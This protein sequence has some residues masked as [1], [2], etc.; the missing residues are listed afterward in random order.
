[1]KSVNY[2]SESSPCLS[3]VFNG[4]LRSTLWHLPQNLAWWVHTVECTGEFN[5]K[6][7]KIS[8]WHIKWT[9]TL[10]AKVICKNYCWIIIISKN[11]A[12]FVTFLRYKNSVKFHHKKV[13]ICTSI[14]PEIFNPETNP[15]LHRQIH[16]QT[17][18]KTISR[19]FRQIFL[20]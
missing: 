16:I 11:I 17:K 1:M 12:E 10:N 6:S 20:W 4:Q 5:L 19:H 13:Q 8:M 18:H 7:F 3:I 14:N 2:F 9:S 15:L